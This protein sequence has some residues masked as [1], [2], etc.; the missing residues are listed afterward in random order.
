MYYRGW[1]IYQDINA[2]I[3]GRWKA[4]RFGVRI[5]NTTKEGVKRMID[6]KIEDENVLRTRPV[7]VYRAT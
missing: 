1:E 4:L 5:G 3:T 6:A 7:G 2:P